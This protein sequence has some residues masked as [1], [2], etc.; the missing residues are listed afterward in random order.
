MKVAISS[1]SFAPQLAAGD[2]TQL[3][4]LERSAGALGA[5]GAV[6]ARSHFARTDSEYLAQL[7]KVCI[8]V[9]LVPLGID[10]PRLFDA[11]IPAEERLAAIDLAAGIGALFALGTL[12]ERGPVPP[13]TFV[14]AVGAAKAAVRAAKAANITLL[15]CA[16]PGTLGEDLAGLRHFRKDVDSA[17]L[18]YALAAGTDRR[19]AGSRD[20]ELLVTVDPDADLDELAEIDEAARPW[21]LLSGPVDRAR[22]DAVRV[23]AA[24]KL[25]GTADIS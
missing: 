12:P 11:A 19:A 24:R 3:E 9:G 23:A 20:R 6:F 25:L 14:A 5:D 13:A 15:A 4:W 16:A 2:L 17:W 7:R 21:L 10:E 1:V 22:V 8:D 18:C